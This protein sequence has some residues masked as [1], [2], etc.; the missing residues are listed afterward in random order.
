MVDVCYRQEQRTGAGRRCGCAFC[1]GNAEKCLNLAVGDKITF[2]FETEPTG[3]VEITNRL[4]NWDGTAC[5]VA[6]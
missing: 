2:T 6:V 3:G 4:V 5:E 1:D